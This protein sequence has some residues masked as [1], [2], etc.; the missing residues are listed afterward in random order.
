MQETTKFHPIVDELVA[1]IKINNWKHI[2]EEAIQK[3]HAKN[4]PLLKEVTTMEEYL[5]W[6][7]I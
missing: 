3:A 5:N 6:N 1:L 4:V 2:F 7:P